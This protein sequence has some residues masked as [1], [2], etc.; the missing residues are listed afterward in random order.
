M[1]EELLLSFLLLALLPG[2]IFV[3]TY[4][5]DL[6]LVNAGQIDFVGCGDDI[7]GI[8]SSQWYTI[9]FEWTGNEEDTLREVLEENHTL[10]AETTRE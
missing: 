5:V 2:E 4:F 6:F 8:D 9:D 1:L 10:A 3:S 7:A